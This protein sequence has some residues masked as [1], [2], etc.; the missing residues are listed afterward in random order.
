MPSSVIRGHSYDREARRLY[1]TFT[2]GKLYTY[3]EVPPSV[4]LD[5]TAAFSKGT[6]FNKFIKDRY[7][8]HEIIPA[9][10]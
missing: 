9:A 4:Y 6:Y 5:F 7:R 1:I 2:T 10:D 3:E 8:Y